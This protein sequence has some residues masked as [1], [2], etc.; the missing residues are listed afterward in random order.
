M[1]DLKTKIKEK[2]KYLA[3][4]DTVNQFLL[5]ASGFNR[6]NQIRYVY[7]SPKLTKRKDIWELEENW[8]DVAC[9][10]NEALRSLLSAS[11]KY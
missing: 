2:N 1:E 8:I 9:K 11:G 7:C 3:E 5:R 10:Q 6:V 4:G